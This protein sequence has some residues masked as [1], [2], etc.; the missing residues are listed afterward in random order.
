MK[1]LTVKLLVVI[2]ILHLHWTASAQEHKF[3]LTSGTLKFNEVNNLSIEGYNG[4]EIIITTLGR[5]AVP[6][7]AKGLHPIN[8]QGIEDNTGIGLSVSQ[9]GEIVEIQQVM[10]K[11]NS[12]RYQVKVPA[13]VK[14]QV[15]Y[16][17]VHGDE[18]RIKNLQNEVEVS[19]RH[20]SITL[21]NISGPAL[22]NS[23]HGSITASFSAIEP[24]NPISII[25]IHNDV[26]VTLPADAKADLTL[27]SEHGTIYT[28]MDLAYA[29]STGDMRKIS[30][31]IEGTLNGGG[32]QVVLKSNFNNIYLRKK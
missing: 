10:N 24:D 28:D 23:V 2:S 20:N 27:A 5:A 13:N 30:S 17:G 4:N 18:I 7:R 6:E 22:V 31:V 19:T 11:N 9:S 15:S 16:V 14:V 3:P 8:S 32:T 12:G 26:D 1:T 25:S 21:E 29:K